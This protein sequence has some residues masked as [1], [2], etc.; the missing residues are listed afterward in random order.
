MLSNIRKLSTKD[1]ITFLQ[2]YV[3]LGL[4]R[5][6]ILCLPF[7]W[8]APVFGA[9]HRAPIHRGL[10]QNQLA[11]LKHISRG[12]ER[13]ARRTPWNSNCLAKAMVTRILLSK[14][15]IPCIVFFGIAKDKG[16]ETKD[17]AHAWVESG[18]H[19]V[20]GGNISDQYHIVAT[21]AA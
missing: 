16:A 4:S 3:M 13:A 11:Q 15:N 20:V 9:P 8:I 6:A 12:V 1:W 14:N 2:A 7:R 18:D 10:S 19:M 21:F 17:I 5:T